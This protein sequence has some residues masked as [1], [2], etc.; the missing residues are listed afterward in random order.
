MA[1]SSAERV[2][3]H[4]ARKSGLEAARARGRAYGTHEADRQGLLEDDP[5]RHR[6]IARAEAYAVWEFEGKPV[7]GVPLEW[8]SEFLPS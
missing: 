8:P 5:A 7:T 4:R 6:R 1:Q 3:A 2:A